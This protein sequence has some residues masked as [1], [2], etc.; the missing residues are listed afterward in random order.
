MSSGWSDF[1]G[2]DLLS[3]LWNLSYQRDTKIYSVI[4]ELRNVYSRCYNSN[5]Q[6]FRYS[7]FQVCPEHVSPP[8]CEQLLWNTHIQSGFCCFDFL[9]SFCFAVM[10]GVSWLLSHRMA[11]WFSHDKVKEIEFSAPKT[12]S[13]FA[14]HLPFS[15]MVWVAVWSFVGHV[16]A[17]LPHPLNGTS[18]S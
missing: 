17:L 12:M 15:V 16:I 6:Y 11:S 2:R 5:L 4:A 14:C 1:Y 13:V 7:T 3:P 8:T 18:S 10:A 9:F